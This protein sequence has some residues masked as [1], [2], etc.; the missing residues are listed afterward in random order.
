[1]NYGSNLYFLQQNTVTLEKKG[2]HAIN[3]KV[4]QTLFQC[5]DEK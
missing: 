2:G 1:M 4:I 5:E 3:A